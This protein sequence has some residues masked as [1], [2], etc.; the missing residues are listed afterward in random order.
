[1][2]DQEKQAAAVAHQRLQMERLR[3]EFAMAAL[4]GYMASGDAFQRGGYS[5]AEND[6]IVANHCWALADAI[7]A[8][9]QE[10]PK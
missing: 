9:R 3:D 8:A 4:G 2:T 6:R 5:V 10:Q 1:M 7:L